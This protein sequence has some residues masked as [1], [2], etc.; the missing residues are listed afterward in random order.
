MFPEFKVLLLSALPLTEMRLA[1]PLALFSLH[2][3]FWEATF[4]S[5]LGNFLP[6]P[7]L[8]FFLPRVEKFLAKR[9]LFFQKFFHWWSERVRKKFQKDYLRLGEIALIF[10]VAL[11][12]PG[13]GAWSGALA[14]YLF[15]IPPKSAM[16][17]IALGLLGTVII[18]ASLF[19][20][21]NF[22]F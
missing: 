2:L 14:A 22:L 5:L 12:L 7:F 16:F 3:N 4:F 13:T 15:Q 20:V 11:P 6:V 19:N 10:F 9:F 21:L 8:L 17:L 18:L 1:F